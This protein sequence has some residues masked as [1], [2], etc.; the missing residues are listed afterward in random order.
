LLLQIAEVWERLIN[1]AEQTRSEP[2][3]DI[4]RLS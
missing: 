3:G 4:G 2:D 1:K